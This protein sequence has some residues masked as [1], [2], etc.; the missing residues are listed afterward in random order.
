MPRGSLNLS[1]G[2]AR[3]VLEGENARYWLP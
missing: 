1:Y 2:R 3:V